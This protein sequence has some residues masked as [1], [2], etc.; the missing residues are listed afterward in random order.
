[1]NRRKEI[2]KTGRISSAV[3]QQGGSTAKGSN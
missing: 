1:V 3:E 2:D